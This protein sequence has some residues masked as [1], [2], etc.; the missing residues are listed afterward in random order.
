MARLRVER[1]PSRRKAQRL[2]LLAA[3]LA[4]LSG[5]A[6]T[7]PASRVAFERTVLD[8]EGPVDTWLKTVGDL[9]GDQRADLIAS[10]RRNSGLVWYEAPTW[11]K[12]VIA[13]DGAFSTDGEVA[14]ADSDGDNDIVVIRDKQI[15]WLENPSWRSHTIDN[16]VAHDVEVADFDNDGQRDIATARMQQGKSPEI[17]VYLNDGQGKAWT[18]QVVSLTSSHSMRILDA[19]GDGRLDLFGADWRGSRVIELWRNVT[20]RLSL[21]ASRATAS[22]PLR[23]ESRHHASLRDRHR[24]RR[25]PGCRLPVARW[26]RSR[27]R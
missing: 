24:S 6:A 14:D 15:V 9:N 25:S 16:V 4:P 27:L 13:A 11:K 20:V 26:G 18:K 19:D 5:V 1:L 8:T 23:C 21:L 3:L 12:H 10:G 17:A 22:E 7:P 2:A